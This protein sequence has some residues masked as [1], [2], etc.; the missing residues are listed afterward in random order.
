MRRI[1]AGMLRRYARPSMI[2]R[3][4]ASLALLAVP[5]WSL[6][7]TQPPR[8]SD[9]PTAQRPAQAPDTDSQASREQTQSSEQRAL[10]QK[11]NLTDDV[12]LRAE[13]YTGNDY[14]K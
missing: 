9:Q 8:G 14:S 13:I 10:D 2:G 12:R 7:Q 6:A 3:L 4:A 5:T 1:F 11:P